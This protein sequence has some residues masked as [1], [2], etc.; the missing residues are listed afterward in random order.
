MGLSRVT[1][2]GSGGTRTSTSRDWVGYSN[3][4]LFSLAEEVCS[5]TEVN[6][7]QA[8]DWYWSVAC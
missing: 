1:Q 2:P 5:I 3:R 4:V 6:N 8:E 7:L